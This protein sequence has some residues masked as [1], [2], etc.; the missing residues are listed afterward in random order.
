M[1]KLLELT[2]KVLRS[3]IDKSSKDMVK[4]IVKD[5][6]VDTGG[7]KVSKKFKN[8]QKGLFRATN[9]VIKMPKEE[10]MNKNEEEFRLNLIRR[11]LAEA[12]HS[13]G[14]GA[15]GTRKGGAEAKGQDT[16]GDSH[17]INIARKAIGLGFPVTLHHHDKNRTHITPQLG[18]Q[19][20]RKYDSHTKP[21]DK[22]EMVH[23]L[24]ASPKHLTG[25]MSGKKIAEPKKGPWKPGDP[26]PAKSKKKLASHGIK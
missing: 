22:E 26:V 13:K 10:T 19:I 3:Y 8:R 15:K 20:M 2:H 16:E 6:I 7:K 21:S 25:Y 9:R 1:S 14:G 24:W 17:P 11:I 12:Q 18:H 5:N 4:H 23:H